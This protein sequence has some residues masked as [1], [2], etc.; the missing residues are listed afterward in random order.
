[1]QKQ[2]D[3]KRRGAEHPDRQQHAR[4]DA[5]GELAVH[6]LPDAVH[7]LEGPED[8]ADLGPAQQELLAQAR[9]RRRHVLPT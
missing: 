5:L 6:E 1:V 3:V 4:R 2:E 9:D 7:E 8:R